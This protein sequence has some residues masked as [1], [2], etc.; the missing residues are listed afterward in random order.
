MPRAADAAEVARG[1]RRGRAAHP[2]RRSRSRGSS[3][4]SRTSTGRRR[5]TGPVR[6]LTNP[7]RDYAWGSRTAIARLQG[8]PAPSRRPRGR[9]LDGR[10]P[11]GAVA[12]WPTTGVALPDV[13]AADPTGDP[14]RRRC[15]AGSAPRLPF[16]LKV[17]AAAQPLSLQVHPDAD[18]AR[19]GFAAEDRPVAGD[20]GSRNYVDP[21]HKPEL[22]VAL[23]PF[24]ALCGFRDPAASAA[25]LAALGLP[26]ARPAH[27][28]RCGDGADAQRLRTAVELLLSWPAAERADLVGRRRPLPASGAPDLAV[29]LARAATRP[30]S[31]SCSPCCSTRSGCAPDEAVFMPAG[32]LHAYLR[33]IGRRGHGGERQRAA[34]RPDPQARR[35]GRDCC[36]SCATRCWPTRC[37]GR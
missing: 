25:E 35:R 33:G 18:Q 10:A 8:R 11:G 29:T 22:L 2:G 31:G 3:T 14:G 24:E 9:A 5:L 21:Y 36:G 1:D 26:G 13:I 6:P 37:C 12:C 34:L 30:T 19:A 27:R 16:L 32:N 15:W 7:V 17:L 20:A 23:E 28:R 4:S